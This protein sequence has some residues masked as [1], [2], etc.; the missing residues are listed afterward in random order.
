MSASK[1]DRVEGKTAGVSSTVVERPVHNP[2]AGPSRL[3]SRLPSDQNHDQEQ[4]HEYDEDDEED[5]DF[6]ND[7]D[8][9]EYDLDD[10]LLAREVALAY[11]QNR[12]YSQLGQQQAQSN[13]LTDES[14]EGFD[15]SY[16]DG[17]GSQDEEEEEGG[18]VLGLPQIVMPS[19]TSG[20]GSGQRQMPSI[21]NP[22]PDNLR[23]FVRVGKLDNGK[24]VLAPGE[25]G[26][27]DEEEVAGG[28]GSK[29]REEIK[30]ALLG[31]GPSGSGSASGSGAASGSGLGAGER[32]GER[33]GDG[34]IVM[35]PVVESA[36][37]ASVVA[38]T[39]AVRGVVQERPTSDK[40]SDP[41]APSKKVSRFKAARMG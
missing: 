21:I 19:N 27:S 16:V 35:P 26:W 24:L 18:V 36:G 20:D 32:R 29:N 25:D 13:R 41:V 15:E 30:A 31:R 17:Y 38:T 28:E 8:D 1:K 33:K 2:E 11:H 40:P 10:A 7:V 34:G 39:A 23:R 4:E 6:Y 22:T 37:P 5:D 9:D 12:A 3:T 14:A